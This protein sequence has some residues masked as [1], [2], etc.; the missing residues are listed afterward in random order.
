VAAQLT[1]PWRPRRIAAIALIVGLLPSLG[2]P[3]QETW[4]C[5]G[6]P[7][8]PCATRHG[9]LS[10]QNGIARRIWLVGTN[11]VVSVY[12]TELPDEI[13]P[14]L[15]LT[16]EDHAYIFGDF[17]ICP[18]EP[19]TPGHMRSVCVAAAERLVVQ[20]LRRPGPAFRLLSTWPRV[21]SEPERV[22]EPVESR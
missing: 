7:V 22:A 1:P 13:Q 11:R 16:S 20:P 17:E 10:S 9:R 19:D 14:Y 3:G 21:E 8:E 4:R 12:D 15:Q 5:V 18:L 6:A 2:W